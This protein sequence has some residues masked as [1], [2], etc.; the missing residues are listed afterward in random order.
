MTFPVIQEIHQQGSLSIENVEHVL[1]D[2]D[3]M[4]C[5][6]GLQTH[7]DG[8]VWVCIN[9]VAFLRFKPCVSEK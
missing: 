2:V 7:S 3:L 9:G 5:D 6:L 1:M 8:R 4:K